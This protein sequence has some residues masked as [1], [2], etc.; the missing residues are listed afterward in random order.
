[1]ATAQQGSIPDDNCNDQTNHYEVLSLLALQRL[2]TYSV[3]EVWLY[4]P[5]YP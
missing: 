2:P 4:L 5:G 1:M 3:V